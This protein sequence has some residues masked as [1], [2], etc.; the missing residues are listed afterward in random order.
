MF[1]RSNAL[2]CVHEFCSVFIV[3]I[4][5]DIFYFIFMN[6]KKKGFFFVRSCA[7]LIIIVI[8]VDFWM[9]VIVTVIY[10]L[11]LSACLSLSR[12]LCHALPLSKPSYSEHLNMCGFLHQWCVN[13][14]YNISR[15]LSLSLAHSLS[16]PFH[17]S[18]LPSQYLF[19]LCTNFK[20]IKA[21]CF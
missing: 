6:T 7:F 3:I 15:S 9:L 17:I 10:S 20:Q 14:L 2:V 18:C 11:Y 12:S 16:P 13:V 19:A 1:L 21:N 8:D 5:F 4:G